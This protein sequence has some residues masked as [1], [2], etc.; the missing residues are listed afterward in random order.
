MIYD[1]YNRLIYQ[2]YYGLDYNP[3]TNN[4][5]FFVGRRE[6]DKKGVLTGMARYDSNGNYLGGKGT[7]ENNSRL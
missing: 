4:D 7:L 6:Y 5:G 1:F 2:Y 3:I